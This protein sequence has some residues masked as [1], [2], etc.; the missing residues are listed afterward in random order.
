MAIDGKRLRGIHGE[1][2]SGVHLVAACA[3]RRLCPIIE[4]P[5]NLGA[6]EGSVLHLVVWFPT[7]FTIDV[8]CS[9]AYHPSSV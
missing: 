5:C 6:G 3:G 7:P 1:Q 2:L 8:P 9:T 4:R